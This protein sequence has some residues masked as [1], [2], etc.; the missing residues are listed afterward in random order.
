MEG[1]P[2]PPLC[3]PLRGC[4]P[5]APPRVPAD[6]GKFLSWSALAVG[7]RLDACT[8]LGGA[9]WGGLPVCC[10]EVVETQLAQCVDGQMDTQMIKNGNTAWSNTRGWELSTP[11]LLLGLRV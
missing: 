5:R 7:P 8:W 1:A 9:A 6:T 11:A 4:A 2:L 10:Q 3:S